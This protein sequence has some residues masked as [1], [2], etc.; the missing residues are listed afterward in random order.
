MQSDVHNKTYW[1]VATKAA[2]VTGK[3]HATRG[4]KKRTQHSKC[5]LKLTRARLGIID[6]EKMFSP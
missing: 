6:V 2:I 5:P 3:K 1:V 4:I